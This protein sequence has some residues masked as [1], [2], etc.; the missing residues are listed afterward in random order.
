M[1]GI[2][3][4]TAFADGADLLGNGIGGLG[5]AE[6]PDD[7]HHDRHGQRAA[8]VAD[9][10]QPP[11]TQ[12]AADGDAR[13]LVDQRQWAQRKDAGEQVETEQVKQDE[14]DR[15]QHGANQRLAG[16]HGD[17][18]GEGGGKRQDGAGHVGANQG[19]AGGH[20]NFR[21]ASVNHFGDEFGGC[22]IGHG[23]FLFGFG[24]F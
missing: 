22:Q 16:L 5:E 2:T 10:D 14:A 19:I 20:E 21:F 12:D 1:R 6:S 4:G 23:G 7:R 15:E 13:T 24:L 8:E 9:E 17:S 18:D 3:D 11:V